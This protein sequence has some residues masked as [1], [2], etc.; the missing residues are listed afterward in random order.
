MATYNL[1]S[2][3]KLEQRSARKTQ[4]W[5]QRE[6]QRNRLEIKHKANGETHED[7]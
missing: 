5:I 2:S 6:I 1:S 7:S 3:S 4:A